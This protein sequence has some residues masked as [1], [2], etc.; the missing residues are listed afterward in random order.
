MD[1]GK[2]TS[3]EWKAPKDLDALIAE[4]VKTLS[5]EELCSLDVALE[6]LTTTTSVK[7]SSTQDAR[8]LRL[9]LVSIFIAQITGRL[10]MKN[11]LDTVE[12]V[13]D[14]LRPHRKA[15]R[16]II[17]TLLFAGSIMTAF[18]AG[19]AFGRAQVA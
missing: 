1:K 14:A 6:T 5:E 8:N 13:T 9:L 7:T 4:T 16:Y 3:D 11:A 19:Y 10:P 15:N 17:R 12:I 18:Y 2:E